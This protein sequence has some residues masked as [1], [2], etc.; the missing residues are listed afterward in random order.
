M[1]VF[2]FSE[3]GFADSFPDFVCKPGEQDFGAE[4]AFERFRSVWN[5]IFFPP[6]AL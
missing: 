3:Q 6:I 1:L 5:T 2:L 4:F